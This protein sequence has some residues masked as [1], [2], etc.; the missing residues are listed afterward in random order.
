MPKVRLDVL[1]VERGLA[2]SRA[3]AQRLVMAGQVRI[4]G[5]VALKSAVS[6]DV[7]TR[8]ELEQGP[9]FVSRGGEKL[10]AALLG[11][12]IPIQDLVCADVGAST[13]G[14]TDCLLQY[15]A[16]KV[17]AIDVGQGILHWKLRQDKRVVVL[18]KTNARYLACLPEPVAL[19]T[20]DASF[21]SLKILL[22]V[23]RAWLGAP[24]F[25]PDVAG[26]GG[27]TAGDVI[28]LIKPQF[29]AGRKETARG[30]GVIRDPI[31]H[32]EI[33]IGLLNFVQAEGYGFRGLMRSPLLGPKGNAEF[34]VLLE[35]PGS[36]PVDP[37]R[38]VDQVFLLRE[39]P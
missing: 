4:E 31:I 12:G 1:M 37:E 25:A 8:I 36:R 2:E 38:L 26:K 22:P 28:A 18:E 39:E 32:R 3:Q 27:G 19:V 16:A 10:E 20:V 35:H 5:Q 7:N 14:F 11:F 23:V 17:Y 15:G 21:I 29:E 13:G 9:R 34:L 6:L 30:H 33:L 24:G